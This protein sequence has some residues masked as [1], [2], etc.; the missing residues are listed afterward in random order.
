[1]STLK[2]FK[3]LKRLHLIIEEEYVWISG[4]LIDVMRGFEILRHLTLKYRH[5]SVTDDRFPQDIDINAPN[6]EYFETNR[7]FKATDRTIDTLIKF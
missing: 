2:S 7:Q 3:N 1:M 6:L 5:M 4:L